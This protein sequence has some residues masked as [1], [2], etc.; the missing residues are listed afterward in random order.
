MKKKFTALA[1]LQNYEQSSNISFTVTEVP[2]LSL[3]GHD[4]IATLGIL[5]C[6]KF[7]FN[8]D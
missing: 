7:N 2:N 5:I 1:S 8:I 4:A 3:L 6:I